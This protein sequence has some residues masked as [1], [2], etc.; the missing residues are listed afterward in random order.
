MHE[1]H[2]HVMQSPIQVLSQL[3]VVQNTWAVVSYLEKIKV[4]ESTQTSIPIKM[5]PWDPTLPSLFTARLQS[6]EG[7]IAD[8]L[9]K[10]CAN[11]SL[12]PQIPIP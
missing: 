3:I 11:K 2:T 7:D 10:W 12:C 6:P 4:Q 9:D 8:K 1:E 5:H